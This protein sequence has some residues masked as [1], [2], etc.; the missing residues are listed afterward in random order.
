MKL[1]TFVIF[2]AFLAIAI[3]LTASAD[4]APLFGAY[5]GTAHPYTDQQIQL[6]SE[7]VTMTILR[8]PPPNDQEQ[9]STVTV[10]YVFRNTSDKSIT[11]L[12]G[13]PERS[14]GDAK[15]KNFQATVNGKKAAITYKKD[16]AMIDRP[17]EPT[18]QD[19]W[20]SYTMT[21]APHEDVQVRNTYEQDP[22]GGEG[23]RG[24]S[25][26]FEYIL[27]TGASWKGVIESVDIEIILQDGTLY[28]VASVSPLPDRPYDQ[29]RISDDFKHLS[30]TRTNLKPTMADNIRISFGLQSSYPVYPGCNDRVTKVEDQDH[31]EVATA[32]STKEID[33]NF[34]FNGEKI[35]WG[36]FA[37]KANDG[38]SQTAW[39]SGK[40]SGNPILSLKNLPAHRAFDSLYI[41]PGFQDD[42]VSPSYR[43]YARPKMIKISFFPP[44]ALKPTAALIL[45]IP[46]KA[47]WNDST[48][49]LGKWITYGKTEGARMDIEV[50][51]TYPGEKYSNVAI[52]EIG[53]LGVPEQ[54]GEHSN[55]DVGISKIDTGSGSTD[56][57]VISENPRSITSTGGSLPQL[58]VSSVSTPARMTLSLYPVIITIEAAIII[59]LGYTLF[60]KK[61]QP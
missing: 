13:F 9:H 36:F 22:W 15:L 49:T 53:L 40:Q 24:Y 33:R 11:V 57:L 32:T 61:R 41:I 1:S 46:D 45:N 21:F 25:A 47:P 58:T 38:D 26:T 27:D 30:L 52:S 37:C 17:N 29:W 12:T 18:M 51:E 5:S 2:S 54:L 44:H 28:N 43:H 23:S 7:K 16:D 10:D 60:R 50:L 55:L 34:P 8:N 4:S 35:P 31:P 48:Y 19:G 59:G 14:E 42:S 39:I 3:P 6:Q 20:Y 56:S